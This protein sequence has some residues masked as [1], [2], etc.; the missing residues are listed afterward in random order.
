MTNPNWSFTVSYVNNVISIKD[1]NG[2]SADETV[3]RGETGT[4]TF[5]PGS[6]VR[7]VT[8]INIT[9]PA[10]LPEGVSVTWTQ[11][12]TNLVVTDIDSLAATDSEVDVSY[13]VE[14][15]DSNGNAVTSDP[16]L[17]NK[18]SLRGN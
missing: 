10:T 16:M 12:G 18:P 6:G 13:C 8:G 9:S 3:F 15:T 11:R 5:Q 4:L 1:P 7:A 14:F 17:V 2:N